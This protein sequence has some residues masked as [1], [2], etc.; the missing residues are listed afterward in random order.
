MPS[1]YLERRRA[2]IEKFEYVKDIS[3]ATTSL[4]HL[5]QYM[6]QHIHEG[7]IKANN[8]MQ[9]WYSVALRKRQKR[10][11]ASATRQRIS[12]NGTHAH[13]LSQQSK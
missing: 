7:K 10:I 2:R 11:T 9:D 6:E 4:S 3:A 12:M 8:D 5:E 13:T 1:G